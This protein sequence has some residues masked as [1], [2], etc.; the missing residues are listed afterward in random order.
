M[1]CNSFYPRIIHAGLYT[2]EL[3]DSLRT[4]AVE[5]PTWQ[6]RNFFFLYRSLFSTLYSNETYH[7]YYHCGRRFR[8][9]KCLA[10]DLMARRGIL[11]SYFMFVFR[12][13]VET[14]TTTAMCTR[15]ALYYGSCLFKHIRFANLISAFWYF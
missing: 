12:F 13:L 11:Q 2:H 4:R 1:N 8:R 9:Q 3:K 5:N 10:N 7:C 6:A 14:T 15:L